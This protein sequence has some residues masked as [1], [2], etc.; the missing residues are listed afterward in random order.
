MVYGVDILW[1]IT[2]SSEIIG[3]INSKSIGKIMNVNNF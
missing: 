3:I 1:V 2:P